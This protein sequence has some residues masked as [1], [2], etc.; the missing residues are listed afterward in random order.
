MI[1]KILYSSEPG[2]SQTT[3]LAANES[4]SFGKSSLADVEIAAQGWRPCIFVSYLTVKDATF[5]IWPPRPN[6]SP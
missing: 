3:V 1:V 2:N 5:T 6:W 4:L